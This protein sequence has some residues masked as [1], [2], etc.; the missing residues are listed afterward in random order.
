MRL[1]PDMLDE[2]GHVMVAHHAAL[3]ACKW[4]DVEGCTGLTA[5][6]AL[7]KCAVLY[8]SGCTGL[9]S[10]ARGYA[11]TRAGVELLLRAAREG[12]TR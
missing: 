6:P 1:T 5:L 2:R 7:P 11:T 3:A 12:V 4:L 9:P 8:A 10:G